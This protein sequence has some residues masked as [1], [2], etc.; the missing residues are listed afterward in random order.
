M[1]GFFYDNAFGG[2]YHER[3]KF[4]TREEA[5]LKLAWIYAKTDWLLNGW[6]VKKLP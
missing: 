5:E 1:Y 2:E 3:Y 6:V 4:K